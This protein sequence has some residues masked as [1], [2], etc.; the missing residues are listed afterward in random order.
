MLIKEFAELTGVSVRT[1][2]YYD[3]IGLLKPAFADKSTGYRFYDENSLLRMQEILFYRELDFPL[4]SIAEILSSPDHD[5]KK[6]LEEQRKLLILKKERL[7]RIISSIDDAMK[8]EN[9]MSAF[10]NSEFEKYKTEAREKWGRTKAFEE[11]ES[12]SADRGKAENDF[13]CGEMMD[14]FR[15]IGEIK[16]LPADS[17]E[18]QNL[19]KELQD[20]ITGNYY[21]CTDE[22]L[23]GLGKMYI[24]DERF[25]NNID[26][27][28][29]NGTAE[30][31]A[32]A[33]EIYCSK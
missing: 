26:K 6:S 10:D 16:N 25:K 18:A 1:L 17:E 3:E 5:T 13:L 11:Y 21:T 2:H 29:G 4:R 8:G 32:K 28:G 15:R 30:F 12:K 14:I 20:F 19:V 33:I 27:A 23:S 9:I 31:A 7:E 22:I 24:G